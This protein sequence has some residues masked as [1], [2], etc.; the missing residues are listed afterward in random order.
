M[1]SSSKALS[2][3]H[4]NFS[5]EGFQPLGKSRSKSDHEDHTMS[6]PLEQVVSHGSTGARRAMDH[7]PTAVASNTTAYDEKTKGGLFHRHRFAGRRRAKA[8]EVSGDETRGGFSDDDDKQILTK[9]GKFYTKVLNFSIITRY[10]IYVLPVAS[11]IAIPIIIGATVA[12]DARIGGP[13]DPNKQNQDLASRGAGVTI[14]AFFAWVEIVWLSIWVS[15]IVAK[16][17]PN[18]FEFFLG[19]VSSGTRKYAL[20]IRRLEI[21][22]SLVGWAVTSLATFRPLMDNTPNNASDHQHWEDVL[23]SIL[24]ASLIA[25]IIFL[26]EKLLV[27]V[28]SIN[29][30]RTQFD[31]RIK[32]NKRHVHLLSLLYDASRSLFP[33]Y[34]PEFE[35]E[36]YLINDSLALSLGSKTNTG[37]P[38]SASPVKF[39]HNI[40]RFGDQITA[41]FGNVA[42][43][44]T[45]K[46][47]FKPDSAHGIV[48]EALEKTRSSEALARR[49]WMSFVVEG[50]DTLLKEDIVEVLGEGRA[51]E[52]E[53]CFHEMDKDGNGD[54]SLDEMIL[55]VT[56]WGRDRKSVSASM[57]DVDQA[58]GALDDLLCVIVLLIIVFVFVGFLNASFSTTLATAGTALLSLSFVFAATVQEVLGSC[59]FLFSKHP[60]D[61][62]D[63][64]DLGQ[65]QLTV[66][67]IAL[68]Y[69][70]FKRVSNGK[71]VQIPNLILNGLWVENVSRSKAMY[72][73]ISL[74]VHFGTTFE[75]IQLL[76]REMENFVRDKDNNRDFHPDI[77]VDV[78]SVAELNK[79][80]LSV[81]LRHKSNWANGTLKCARRNKFFCALVLAL[82]K[83]PIYGPGGPDAML[84]DKGK[85]TYAVAISET[86]AQKARE[87]YAASIEAARM[88][89]TDKKEETSEVNEQT[90]ERAS[91]DY[92]GAGDSEAK[93]VGN[94]TMRSPAL[95]IARDD[96]SSSA[97]PR[98]STVSS[99]GRPSMD[100]NAH[101]S[102]H[103]EPSRGKRRA[104]ST[105]YS[106]PVPAIIEPGEGYDKVPP[107][108]Y[109]QNYAPRLQSTRY[110]PA[111]YPAPQ[112]PLSRLQ[113]Q[114]QAPTSRP[115]QQGLEQLSSRAYGGPPAPPYQQ[116]DSNPQPM[117][118]FGAFPSAQPAPYYSVQSSPPR[119]NAPPRGAG[120]GAGPAKPPPPPK[121]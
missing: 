43:E 97:T 53:E 35:E 58:I 99:L 31:Q 88:V 12:P 6:I 107:L 2:P 5:R 41:A 120:P 55:M 101:N 4:Y 81:S 76:R 61:V 51:E 73:S 21:P 105:E 106:E 72:E 118:T 87:E 98:R 78:V 62:G 17:L 57:H 104:V 49:L 109:D 75:D 90:G 113:Q 9:M 92:L 59:V 7:S 39:L 20:A 60:F 18:I 33:A 40:G 70:V 77:D 10:F 28:I 93:A 80:E 65:E 23:Q 42:Q 34:C 3:T 32:A 66:E 56:Q 114:R 74:F 47:V 52:A 50:R 91:I 11:V 19:V 45:G 83:V 29:Y 85:P 36:D 96:A 100:S 68:L 37:R 16:F 15:K 115:Q 22:L 111:P 25:S 95:D 54:I 67:S 102:L 30:H 103:R 48:V 84:G 13:G 112:L 94:L 117:P 121:T 44:I 24:A 46:E 108:N 71:T 110:Q 64:V 79:L 63:R 116:E 86:E 119:G 27:Q 69:T 89:P 8:A 38:K 14:I 1:P 82:R 26:V